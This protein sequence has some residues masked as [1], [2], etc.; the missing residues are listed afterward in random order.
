MIGHYHPSLNTF[1]MIEHHPCI[2]Q[3]VA[4]LYSSNQIKSRH[5]SSDGYLEQINLL[6]NLLTKKI[7]VL[8][9]VITR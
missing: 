5:N 1:D 4:Q 9:I 8:N 2:L 7:V 6:P 3:I